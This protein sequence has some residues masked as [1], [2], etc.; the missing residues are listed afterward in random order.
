MWGSESGKASVIFFQSFNLDCDWLAF[1][2]Q[3]TH[4][5]KRKKG[6]KKTIVLNKA[7]GWLL[8][9]ATVGA[10]EYWESLSWHHK[11]ALAMR[12]L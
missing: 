12:G 5:T 9:V 3:H 8:I 2:E 1:A 7:N 11:C 4:D 10:M 6:G